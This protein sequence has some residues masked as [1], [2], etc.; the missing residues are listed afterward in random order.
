[1]VQCDCA[2]CCRRKRSSGNSSV[3][4]RSFVKQIRPQQ[5]KFAISLNAAAHDTA[6]G[7]PGLLF[8]A[9]RTL[10]NIPTA[11]CILKKKRGRFST[12]TVSR[13]K[14]AL[15]SICVFATTCVYRA[16]EINTAMVAIHSVSSAQKTNLT[17]YPD[18]PRI[19]AQKTRTI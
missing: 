18:R 9:A 14:L 8:I 17:P 16:T 3:A 13:R 12:R 2:R 15:V 4:A 6:R 19:S 10:L 11:V 5:P 7:L 1:M